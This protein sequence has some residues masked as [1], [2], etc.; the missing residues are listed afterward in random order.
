[1]AKKEVAKKDKSSITKQ[2]K[3]VSKRETKKRKMSHERR[4]SESIHR[5]SLSTLCGTVAEEQGQ[6]PDCSGLRMNSYLC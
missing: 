6:R 2:N 3:E 1:M 5:K 4:V